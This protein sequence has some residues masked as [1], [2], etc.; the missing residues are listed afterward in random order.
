MMKEDGG[1]GAGAEE[2]DHG[3]HPGGE[4]VHHLLHRRRRREVAMVLKYGAV[5]VVFVLAFICNS[6]AI[7]SL[8]QATFLVSA[9]PAPSSALRLRVPVTVDYVAGAMERGFLLNFAG[10]RLFYAG[11][12]LLLWIFGPILSCI[13][14]MV[15]VGMMSRATTM[16]TAMSRPIRKW[17]W[18][19]LGV[20]TA[21][22][23]IR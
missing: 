10:N 12:P 19:L 1:G 7:C 5:L 6:H 20:N 8:N 21:C 16:G 11:V 13:C 15:M 2:R 17:R 3:V 18:I 23:L 14:S 22:K 9:L 4:H